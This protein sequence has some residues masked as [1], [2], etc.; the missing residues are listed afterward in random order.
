MVAKLQNGG[1]FTNFVEYD[2]R[3]GFLEMFLDAYAENAE[4]SRKEPGVIST[5]IA[6]SM[7]ESTP[8]KVLITWVFQD[9]G[10]FQDHL[11]TEHCTKY[12]RLVGSLIVDKRVNPGRR[13]ML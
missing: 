8:N 3:P 2:I 9:Y 11:L 12:A 4:A 1:S 6:V 7:D 10:A 5:E 13:L